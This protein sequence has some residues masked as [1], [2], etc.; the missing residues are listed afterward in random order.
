[1]PPNYGSGAAVGAQQCAN[2]VGAVA[3]AL[4]L[5]AAA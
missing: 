3:S 2:G 1:M 4:A 5:R